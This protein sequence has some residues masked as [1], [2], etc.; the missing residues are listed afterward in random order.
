MSMIFFTFLAQMQARNGAKTLQNRG[1][2]VKLARTPAKLA[3]RGCSYG[4]WVREDQAQAAAQALRGTYER[5]YR[6]TE[7]RAE[8]VVL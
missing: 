1:I 4:L 7:G 3:Q 2:A 5:S 8:E 6:V